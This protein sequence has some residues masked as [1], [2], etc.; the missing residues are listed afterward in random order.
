MIFRFENY[1]Q[2]FSPVLGSAELFIFANIPTK[3][4][5]FS[6]LI[7]SKE[8]SI[9]ERKQILDQFRETASLNAQC[10]DLK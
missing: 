8:G 5:L 2:R 1:F 4:K 6:L 7:R 10:S 9:Q 3:A